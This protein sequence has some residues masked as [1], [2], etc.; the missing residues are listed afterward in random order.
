MKIAYPCI[1]ASEGGNV[2]KEFRV[3]VALVAAECAAV[4]C[5]AIW[6]AIRGG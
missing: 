3:V 6:L 1:I 4:L 5:H 2:P